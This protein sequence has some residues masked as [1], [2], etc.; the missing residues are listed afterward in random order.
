M[1]FRLKERKIL[2]YVIESLG[3]SI[4]INFILNSVEL[5]KSR[6]MVI[7]S[8]GPDHSIYGGKILLEKL[9]PEIRASVDKNSTYFGLH[10]DRI[11]KALAFTPSSSI[12]ACWTVAS[13]FRGSDSITSSK[14][15]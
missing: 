4:N 14:Q 15:C 7:M 1:I 8:M 11:P 3:N 2:I 5:P 12:F 13:Y 9:L 6:V 10:K